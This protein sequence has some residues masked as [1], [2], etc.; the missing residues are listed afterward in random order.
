MFYEPQVL[1]SHLLLKEELL[2][3]IMWCSVYLYYTA[4]LNEAQNP[5]SVHCWFAQIFD[6]VLKCLIYLGYWRTKY[7]KYLV[8]GKDAKAHINFVELKFA[9]LIR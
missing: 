3:V 8:F 7:W 9:K 1:N 6:K 2:S 5:S 4:L